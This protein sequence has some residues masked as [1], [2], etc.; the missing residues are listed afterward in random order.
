MAYWAKAPIPREQMVLIATTLDDRIPDDQVV[1]VFAEILG[2]YDWS[3]WEAYYHQ[4]IGQPP[5]HP[6][7]LASV[8]L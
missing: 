4:G 6:R 2:S 1:R 3:A 5:I 7:V 8:W